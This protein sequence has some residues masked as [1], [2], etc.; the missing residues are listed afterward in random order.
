V[1]VARA[2][3]MTSRTGGR[4]SSGAEGGCG[5]GGRG[6]MRT[7][8]VAQWVGWSRAATTTQSAGGGNGGSTKEWS[9]RISK[10]GVR[11]SGR[12]RLSITKVIWVKLP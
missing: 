10:Q 4:G 6:R 1:G 9:A 5:R 11:L 3:M 7:A 2:A 12:L 8:M